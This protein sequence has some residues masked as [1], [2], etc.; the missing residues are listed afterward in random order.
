MGS[1]QEHGGQKGK[2]LTSSRTL[3]SLACR[4][5]LTGDDV[6]AQWLEVVG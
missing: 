6:L 5:M 3:T 2:T 4:K 1:K